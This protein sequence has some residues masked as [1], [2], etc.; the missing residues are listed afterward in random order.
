VTGKLARRQAELVAY[1]AEQ[2]AAGTS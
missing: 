1:K 2:Q